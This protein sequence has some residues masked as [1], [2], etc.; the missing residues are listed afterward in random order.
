VLGQRCG[1]RFSGFDERLGYFF[2]LDVEVL[3]GSAEHVEGLVGGD[4][5]AFH[6]DPLGLAYQLSCPERLIEVRVFLLVVLAVECRAERQPGQGGKYV[7]LL[8]LPWVS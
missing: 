5:L 3:G 4:P 8:G 2:E 6:Q 1:W 7:G